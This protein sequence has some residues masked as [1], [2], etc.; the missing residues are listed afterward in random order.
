MVNQQRGMRR[1][2]EGIHLNRTSWEGGCDYVKQD[3]LA[4]LLMSSLFGDVEVRERLLEVE[5]WDNFV[6]C[7]I[8]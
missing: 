3:L 5:H 1:I 6:Y 7:R 4:L 2:E 8:G